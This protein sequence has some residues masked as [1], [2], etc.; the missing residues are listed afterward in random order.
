MKVISRKEP[1]YKEAHG[2]MPLSYKLIPLVVALIFGLALVW[3]E[4]WL[5]KTGSDQKPHESKQET[6]L[7][8]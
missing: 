5:W 4:V 6:L 1:L 8:P 2:E 3:G 7:K